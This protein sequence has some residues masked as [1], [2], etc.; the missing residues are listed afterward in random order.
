MKITQQP[1]PLDSLLM[2]YRGGTR[3]ERWGQY[4][5]CF[6]VNLNLKVTLEEFVFAFYTS[7]AFKIERR[8]LRWAIKAGSTDAEARA[9]AG[10]TLDSF[11]VWSV[12]AR[13]DTQL[14]MCDRY[15]STRS[16]FRVVPL[17]D[18]TLLQFGS[19]VAAAGGGEAA[20][21]SSGFK[22]LLGFHVLYSK[23]L[24]R[25]AA[26]RLMA[27]APGLTPP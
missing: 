17:E 9:V 15:E 21:M 13:T 6:S 2:S 14:L 25:A 24:L 1:A 22:L 19:A 3:P 23:V 11:A 8:I 5:D 12:G 4:G 26:K 16:W 27:R 7:W 20:T 18:G 10:G